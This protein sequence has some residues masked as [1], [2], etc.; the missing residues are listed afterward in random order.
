MADK[1]LTITDANF[2][3]EVMQSDKPVL[4]DFWAEWCPPCKMIGPHIDQMAGEYEGRVKIGKVDV[5]SN[6]ALA[7]KFRVSSIPTLI[8]F[9]DG[10]PVQ[11][12]QGANLP[13]IKEAVESA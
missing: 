8:L 2:D 13:A 9:K 3:E 4:L 6:Q 5:E 12:I 10:E 7:G 1:A 11:T